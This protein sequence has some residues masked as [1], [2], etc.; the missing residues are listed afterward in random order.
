TETVGI[1]HANRYALKSDVELQTGAVGNGASRSDL[2]ATDL[3]R[4]VR[5]LHLG[6]VDIQGTV[7]VLNSDWRGG[8]RNGDILQ[9]HLATYLGTVGRTGCADI[10]SDGSGTL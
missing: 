9:A 10:E 3:R 8:G 7:K 6:M 2:A 5:N 4:V 1:S